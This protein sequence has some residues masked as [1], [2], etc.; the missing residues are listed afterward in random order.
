MTWIE[1]TCAVCGSVIPIVQKAEEPMRYPY[2]WDMKARPC[3]KCAKAAAK[4]EPTEPVKKK[5]TINRCDVCG[6]HLAFKVESGSDY[7]VFHTTPCSYCAKKEPDG[8]DALKDAVLDSANERMTG[9]KAEIKE[10]D[11]QIET[12]VYDFKT[13]QGNYR[14][15]QGYL[16]VACTK[17]ESLKHE[18]ELSRAVNKVL[19]AKPPDLETQAFASACKEIAGLKTEVKELKDRNTTLMEKILELERKLG[20][21]RSRGAGSYWKERHGELVEKN[22]GLKTYIS[23]LQTALKKRKADATKD[24]IISA[25]VLSNHHLRADIESKDKEIKVLKAN[26]LHVI[27]ADKRTVIGLIEEHEVEFHRK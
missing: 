6:E 5:Q 17:I 24:D 11:R 18:L 21:S 9:L 16:E 22:H 19:D 14:S 2:R 8:L 10:K 27:T 26:P 3:P 7:V 20:N 1:L 15:V 12:L 25:T 23:S 13:S 4:T